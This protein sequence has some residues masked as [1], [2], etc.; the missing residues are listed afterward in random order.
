M[1]GAAKVVSISPEGEVS[2]YATGLTM[3]TDLRMAPDGELYA[4]QLGEF[5]EQGPMPNSGAIWHIHEGEAS[6]VVYSGLSFPTSIDFNEAGD[7]YITTNGVGEPGSGAVIRVPGLTA[8][9]ATEPAEMAAGA[10]EAV[11]IPEGAMGPEIPQDKGYVVEEIGRGLYW[12]TD[13]SYQI[14]FLTTGEG[15]IVVD[16]PPS[17]VDKIL[18]AIAEVT[19]EPITYVIYSHAHADH[20]GG[21]GLYP[22][23]RNLHRPSGDSCGFGSARRR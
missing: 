1:P 11:P 14:M 20:I 19:D 10:M 3:I 2:D 6:E 23:G 21:A 13:G 8:M 15:V 16:A 18:A 17:M 7:A 4:V 22:R 5:T 9:S 12:V